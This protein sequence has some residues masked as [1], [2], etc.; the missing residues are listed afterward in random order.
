VTPNLIFT[1]HSVKVPPSVFVV[2]AEVAQLVEHSPEKAGV[3]SSILSLGT[4]F[5]ELYG[6]N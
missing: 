2:C 3:D 1:D 4:T 6:L 5:R